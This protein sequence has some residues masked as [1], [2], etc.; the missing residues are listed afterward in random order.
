M[1]GAL[2]KWKP[3]LLCMG[4]ILL[5]LYAG[6]S[7]HAR[8]EFEHLKSSIS[9][10]DQIG[11][12][13]EADLAYKTDKWFFDYNKDFW[14]NITVYLP[15]GALLLINITQIMVYLN[16]YN[17][18]NFVYWLFNQSNT[19]QVSAGES[20]IIVSDILSTIVESNNADFIIENWHYARLGFL[21][22]FNS[23][24]QIGNETTSGDLVN[25]FTEA[26]PGINW[27]RP[28]YYSTDTRAD[29]VHI[30][31]YDLLIDF[32][33]A[34]PILAF[35][36]LGAVV[37]GAY[38]Y[39]PI[40]R[41]YLV[42]YLDRRANIGGRNV[43]L[44]GKRV[45]LAYCLTIDLPDEPNRFEQ[46]VL[47]WVRSHLRLDMTSFN[48][49]EL[50]ESQRI[51]W[52]KA[53][54]RVA[55][56]AAGIIRYLA[57]RAPIGERGDLYVKIIENSGF[58][59]SDEEKG[60]LLQTTDKIIEDNFQQW[61]DE[62]RPGRRILDELAELKTE[63]TSRL[64]DIT[65]DESELLSILLQFRSLNNKLQEKGTELGLTE[66]ELLGFRMDAVEDKR[67]KFAD[68]ILSRIRET[69]I[70]H[71]LG[72]NLEDYYKADPAKL[73]MLHELIERAET[74]HEKG[75]AL[76]KFS[77][78]V[79]NQVRGFTVCKNVHTSSSEID[80]LIENTHTTIPFFKSMGR[81]II[82]E[83]KNWNEKVGIPTIET[84]VGKLVLFGA[85]LAVII[86]R[87]GISG[88]ELRYAWRAVIKAYDKNIG[89][90]LVLTLDD[91]ES[92]AEG[93]NL[94]NLLKSKEDEYFLK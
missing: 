57:N 90:I 88:D 67:E 55:R 83:C 40:Q 2:R 62:A 65:D 56:N 49:T 80:L 23:S 77:E 84:I 94:V 45:T 11:F 16:F 21:V 66:I 59:L 15:S 5:S 69:L 12:Q 46:V 60:I 35:A 39:I 74:P 32:P 52:K 63:I 6:Q 87:E 93:M 51:I 22:Q 61:A 9:V 28:A 78:Y 20:S 30:E 14:L 31:P 41:R 34:V 25:L 64:P 10:P 50:T 29:T 17:D 85:S 58:H 68:D 38:L 27:N 43:N 92:L 72:E 33:Y 8:V 42:F 47:D 82:V 7:V 73:T 81:R 89:S 70:R 37:L 3:L 76:E 44:G 1:V 13:I 48:E 26:P 53:K 36:F 79:F 18:G 71:T 75:V 19:H 24:I 86:T 91:I 4:T 54:Q